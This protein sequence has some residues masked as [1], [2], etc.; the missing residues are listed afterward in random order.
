MRISDWSS[1]VC[2]SDLFALDQGSKALALGFP[3]PAAG[4]EVLPVLNL[5]LVR[6]DGVS[7]G[8]LGGVVPW[9]VL[10]LLGLAIVA[11]LSVWFWRAQTRLAAASLG[12][13]IGG[14]LGNVLDRLDRKSTRLNSRQQ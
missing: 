3:L 6:N 7:F 8:M 13:V 5:V 2:S 11:V 12:L 1:D 10:A 4:L 9:W 14:A